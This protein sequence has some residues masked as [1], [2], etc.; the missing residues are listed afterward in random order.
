MDQTIRPANSVMLFKLETTEG[1]DASPTAADAFPFEADGYSYNTPFTEEQSNEASGSL[2]TGAPLVIGQPA[3]VTIRLRMKGANAAY[4]STVKPPH[5]ALLSSCGLK[6]FFQTAVAA[7]AL[8]AGT[9]TSATLASAFANTPQLYRGM[10]LVLSAG[11][12]NG[13]TSFITDYTSGRVATLVDLF[14]TA[15]TTSTEAAIPANWTYAG[16]SPADGAARITDHPSG[17][18]YIYEDGT[19]LKFVGCSGVPTDWG[20]DTAKPGFM[21]VRLVGVFAGDKTDAAIPN[22]S[23]A[24]HTAPIVVQGPTRPDPAFLVNRK[25]LPIDRWALNLAG[26]IESPADPNTDYGFGPGIIG[27]RDPHLE[28][29]PKATLVATR[30]ILAEIKNTAIYNGVIR[31]MGSQYNRWAI[32]LPQLQPVGASP[33]TSGSLR[34]EQQRYAMNSPGKDNSGRDGE[35]VLCFW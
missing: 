21:T 13:R 18:L 28:C 7:A 23:I 34:T 29:D 26:N 3:E 20:G 9:T 8:T 24:S 22:V 10:P 12:G 17:T 31:A 2:V 15:L 16:T 33:G 14:G 5:H 27:M 35:L 19:L 11:P 4:S 6:G 25:G 30:D 1:V 32:T